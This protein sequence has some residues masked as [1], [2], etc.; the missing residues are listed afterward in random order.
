MNRALWAPLKHLSNQLVGPL[1]TCRSKKFVG[2]PFEDPWT[3][4]A[5]PPLGGARTNSTSFASTCALHGHNP[6]LQDAI[7]RKLL[8]LIHVQR[9]IAQAEGLEPGLRREP[10]PTSQVKADQAIVIRRREFG[11]GSQ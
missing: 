6:R 9:I 11:H 1:F 8:D 7:Q 3:Q 5:W 2:S 4:P 10:A